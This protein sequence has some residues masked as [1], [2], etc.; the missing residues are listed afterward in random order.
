MD[1]DT[2]QCLAS[3]INNFYSLCGV[4]RCDFRSG[5]T[6]GGLCPSKCS[7]SVTDWVFGFSC[8]CSCSLHIKT[9]E[10]KCSCLANDPQVTAE[11]LKWQM[12]TPWKSWAS[13]TAK[14]TVGKITIRKQ[15]QKLIC[16]LRSLIMQKSRHSYPQSLDRFELLEISTSRRVS[17]IMSEFCSSRGSRH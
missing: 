11:G 2:V 10:W 6:S 13:V 16:F 7:V 17:L 4:C 12:E 3:K 14:R 8:S 5:T 15:L 9:K 1:I